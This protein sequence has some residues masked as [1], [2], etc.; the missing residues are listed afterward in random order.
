MH[1]IL[2][3]L[4]IFRTY[5]RFSWFVTCKV[6]TI[7]FLSFVS[8]VSNCIPWKQFGVSLAIC[9]LSEESAAS[10]VWTG[11]LWRH[12]FHIRKDS[13]FVRFQRVN[14]GPTVERKVLSQLIHL[15]SET[16]GCSFITNICFILFTFSLEPITKSVHLAFRTLYCWP[17]AWSRNTQNS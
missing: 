1:G 2:N 10:A 13:V 12:C 11:S 16:K 7:Q 4:Q 5:L 8:G 15:L 3:V 17:T 9:K 14:A 6:I